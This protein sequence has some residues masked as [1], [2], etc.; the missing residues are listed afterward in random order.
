[1][2]QHPFSDRG[3]VGDERGLGDARLREH[4]LVG[5][6]QGH[7]DGTGD[8]LAH[9][10]IKRGCTRL[11]RLHHH[12]IGA[13]VFPQ[14]LEARMPQAPVGCH[15]GIGHFD[16]QLGPHP[17]GLSGDVAGDRN[18]GGL[19]HAPRI[20]L[21]KKPVPHRLRETCADAATVDELVSFV[22][23]E[24]QRGHT[25]AGVTRAVATD[26]ELLPLRALDLEPTAGT[27][28]DVAAVCALGDDA[29]MAAL[30]HRLEHVLAMVD[31][32]AGELQ[33]V[34]RVP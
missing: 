27:V 1:M 11:W 26:D 14:T 21:R 19:V 4:D 12:L 30:A 8:L 20:E 6:G 15:F 32:M 3:I 17:T 18:E 28:A 23:A 16:N 13:L 22:G 33:S 7:A 29:F 25:P 10:G 24:D 34:L 2:R 9:A 5:M 31:D